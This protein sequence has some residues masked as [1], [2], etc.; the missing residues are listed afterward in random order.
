MVAHQVAD[1]GH[2]MVATRGRAIMRKV[3]QASNVIAI[4]DIMVVAPKTLF[5]EE[6]ICPNEMPLLGAFPHRTE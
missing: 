3:D 4:A 6:P 5:P 2:E 1:R